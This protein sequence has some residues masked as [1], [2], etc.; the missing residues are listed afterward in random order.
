MV[1]GEESFILMH[2][3]RF[4]LMNKRLFLLRGDS[5]HIRQPYSYLFLFHYQ[6]EYLAPAD[7]YNHKYTVD[8]TCYAP[9]LFPVVQA[10]GKTSVISQQQTVRDELRMQHRL[11]SSRAPEA[12]FRLSLL[13]L[14]RK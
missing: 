12:M 11:T 1:I 14:Y 8:Q 10:L 6:S 5:A 7:Y 4:V 3:R 9:H 13:K 2:F